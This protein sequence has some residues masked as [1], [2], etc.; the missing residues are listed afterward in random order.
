MDGIKK[1]KNIHADE[2]V[3][4][5]GNGPSLRETPLEQL[6]KE[7]TIATNRINKIFEYTE[8]RPSYFTYPKSPTGDEKNINEIIGENIDCFI[9]PEGKNIF[10]DN[11]NT[12]YYNKLVSDGDD[13]RECLNN[14]TIPNDK[15]DFWSDNLNDVIYRYNTSSFA[16]YQLA[17]Y[18]GFDEIY[19]VGFDLGIDSTDHVLFETGADPFLFFK[20][21]K[22]ADVNLVNEYLKFVSDNG[23]VTRSMLNTIYAI[24]KKFDP[25]ASLGHKFH[26][27][28]NYYEGDEYVIKRGTDD[29]HRRAHK[30]AYKKLDKRGVSIYNATIG[31][32]L[33]IF[34]R[35]DIGS[36]I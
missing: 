34:P 32:E 28:D 1:F 21:N 8:W 24:Y 2:R 7:Y 5:V 27:S 30:L 26:F 23:N 29:A 14:P 15:Y 20:E 18:M 17:N 13:R 31:G 4:L 22:L 35:V 11:S 16:A 33:E 9:C 25:T 6:T 19:L 10:G 36:I 3:F 12:Y